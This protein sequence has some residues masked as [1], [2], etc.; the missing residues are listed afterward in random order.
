MANKHIRDMLSVGKQIILTLEPDSKTGRR[1]S[2]YIRGWREGHYLLLDRPKKIILRSGEECLVHF[3]EDGVACGFRSVVVVDGSSSHGEISRGP[4]FH[5]KWPK[6]V[7]TVELRTEERIKV[8]SACTLTLPCGDVLDGALQD[9]S[10]GGFGVLVPEKLP[11]HVP[12]R[13]TVDLHKGF[14]F[15]ELPATVCN[16]V[17]RGRQFILGCQFTD[18]SEEVKN[19]I[20]FFVAATR[21]G[22]RKADTDTM[23]ILILDDTS[24]RL[25]GVAAGLAKEGY[26]VIP[27]SNIVD[28]FYFVHLQAP[29]VII[30]HLTSEA[31]SGLQLCQ[32]VRGIEGYASLPIIL[33]DEN[34][35]NQRAPLEAEDHT[36][37][38][39]AVNEVVA[40]VRSLPEG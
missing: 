31:V 13:L 4:Q 15:N 12:F 33:L 21:V 23:E 26:V 20:N 36:Q 11:K 14:L 37:I 9:F 34:N 18:I 1:V 32:M 30:A 8:Q 17:T 6:Q 19:E 3:L 39:G 10:L 5:L 28:A 27:T 38:V 29:K 40:A 35:S 22:F 24:G 16:A 7:E 25:K 2:S